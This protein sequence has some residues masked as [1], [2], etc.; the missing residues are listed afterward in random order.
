MLLNDI[1]SNSINSLTLKSRDDIES[2]SMY[3]KIGEHKKRREKN[4]LKFA[5]AK[6]TEM[7]LPLN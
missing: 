6:V 7:M 2:N 1:D 3:H 5:C 4:A